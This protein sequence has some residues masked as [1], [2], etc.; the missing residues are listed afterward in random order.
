MEETEEVQTC[1]QKVLF[2]I[3]AFFVLLSIFSL[4][5]FLFLVPFVIEPAFTTIFMEFDETPAI[6]VTIDN[7]KRL[8][9]RLFQCHV[10]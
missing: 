1:K 10:E 9:A 7:E 5:S 3:T 6:C 8:G 2:H 4:F